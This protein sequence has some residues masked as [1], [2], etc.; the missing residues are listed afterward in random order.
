MFYAGDATMVIVQYG[1]SGA[2]EVSLWSSY[3]QGQVAANAIAAIGN[4]HD[5]FGSSLILLAFPELYAILGVAAVYFIS[6]AI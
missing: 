6:I 5:V 3:R 2:D 4:G 1:K